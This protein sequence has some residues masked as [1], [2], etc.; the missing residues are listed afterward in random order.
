MNNRSYCN[1]AQTMPQTEAAVRGRGRMG[2]FV[3]LVWMLGVSLPA[4]AGDAPS[5]MKTLVNAPVPAHDEKTDAVLMYSETAVNVI[6]ADK[7]K[8]TV[9]EAYKILRPQGRDRGVVQVDLD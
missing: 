7:I 6:S 4:M 1:Q 8:T 5:W 9:R 3:L 2:A